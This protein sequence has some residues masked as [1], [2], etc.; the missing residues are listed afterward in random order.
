MSKCPDVECVINSSTFC[1]DYE[2]DP[3]P[4]CRFWDENEN[5]CMRT[6]E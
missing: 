4:D 1:F 6:E 3:L 2:N 5:R